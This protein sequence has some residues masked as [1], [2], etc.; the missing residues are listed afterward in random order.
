MHYHDGIDL[1]VFFSFISAL[2]FLYGVYLWTSPGNP[3]V[4]GAYTKADR[5]FAVFNHIMPIII[6]LEMTIG[7]GYL[8]YKCFHI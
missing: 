5:F 6:C 7:F 4:K 1:A 2:A 8:A 3:T